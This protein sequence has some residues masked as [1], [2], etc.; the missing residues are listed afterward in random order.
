M[1]S[2]TPYAEAD[3]GH[4]PL[5]VF[6]EVTRACELAC[7]HCRA[8]AATRPHPRELNTAASLDLLDELATF[9]RRPMVVLTGGDPFMRRDLADLTRHA[10][11]L[12]LTPSLSPSAT[13]RVTF[14]S[15]EALRDAGLTRVAVSLDA[16]DAATHDAFRGV[17]G[18]FERALQIIRDC[19]T[20]QLPVQVNTTIHRGNL[21]HV[22]R[23]A[24]LLAELPAV[25]MW[26]VFFLVPV[27]RALR[28]DRIEPAQY[29]TVFMRLAEHARR[30]P[31]AIK[32]TEAPFYRRFMLRRG[33]NPVA[34]RPHHAMKAPL[35][36]NDGKGVMFISHTGT[37]HPSGFMPIDCG[38]FPDQPI[39]QTYQRHP[40]F[41]SLRDPDA[42]GGKC[43]RCEFRGIC[44]GSRAR[45]WNLT[46]DPLAA[47]PDCLYQPRHQ[48]EPEPELCSA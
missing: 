24:K 8:C 42:L 1:A 48:H 43:G 19:A 25:S 40:T 44:G 32:T 23:I 17:T 11:V 9:P 29:E 31:Y 27:G 21:H 33:H 28:M 38:R 13:P 46:G 26:S 20:L 10:A 2:A 7:R 41:T 47:D 4:S 3:F 22:H 30:Q 16:G 35:G 34:D 14:A 18:T 39:V 37:I 5:L 6:Y 45:A 36:I 12:G 15:L